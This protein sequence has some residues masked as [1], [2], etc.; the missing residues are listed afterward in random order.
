[1]RNVTLYDA[2]EPSRA[3]VTGRSY[4]AHLEPIGIDSAAAESLTGYVSR[5][6]AVHAVDTGVLISRELLPRIPLM[7]GVSAGEFPTEIPEYSFGAHALN[8]SGDRSRLWVAVIERLTYV[9]RLDLLTALPWARAIS[10]VHLLRPCRAWC[11]LCYGKTPSG[12]QPPYERL[13]WA[14]QLVAVCPIHRRRLTTVCPSCG[15]EQRAL[16]AKHRPGYC[17]R[18]QCWLGSDGA[19]DNINDAGAQDIRVAEMVGELLA[20]GSSVPADLGTELFRANVASA[21][22]SGRFPLRSGNRRRDVR[23]WVRYAA[24]PR[25]DSLIALS[26]CL[27]VPLIRLLT[28]R[29]DLAGGRTEP[30]RSPKAH[31]KVANATVEAALR[32]ALTAE[33]P[34]S[35]LEIAD[36]LGYKAVAS[37]RK[38]YPLLCQEIADRRP[39]WIEASGKISVKPPVPRAA[40]ERALAAELKREG[41]TNLQTVAASFGVNKRRLYKGFHE[42]RRAIVAKN[43]AIR[44]QNVDAI[45]IAL[46]TALDEQP[47]PTVT[48]MARRLGFRCVSAVTSRFP[49]LSA[50]LRRKRRDKPTEPKTRKN[51]YVHQTLTEAL[52]EVPPP[53]CAEIV[54]RLRGHKTQIREGFPDLWRA[55]R[56]RYVEYQRGVRRSNRETIASEVLRVV[57]ELRRKGINPT[58]RLVFAAIPEPQRHFPSLVEDAVRAARCELS[59][60]P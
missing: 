8:G 19:A 52:V 55:V 5:L 10:C 60:G 36:K 23:D 22:V 35:L 18:C 28:E 43:R 44:K 31:H 27:D 41:I 30:H 9:E 53:P 3:A 47:V 25:M 57:V 14:F 49:E 26:R 12:V 20:Q 37:L 45:A 40:I 32:G 13:L 38:R 1:M 58:Y 17:S 56:A 51:A 39:S 4:L 6:A 59:I 33:A 2:W 34:A 11:S 48:E 24:V 21:S 16:S 42:V 15:R 7:K 46:Q 50:E 54:R 29:I